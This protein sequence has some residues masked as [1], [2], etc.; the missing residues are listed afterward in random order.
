MGSI[1][2]SRGGRENV[3]RKRGLEEGREWAGGEEGVDRTGDGTDEVGEGLA[4]ELRPQWAVHKMIQMNIPLR[5]LSVF[6]STP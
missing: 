2:E 6:K 5:G 3:R 1:G 4:W